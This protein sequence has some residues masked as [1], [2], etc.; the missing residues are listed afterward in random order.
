MGT[1]IAFIFKT[2]M[3][4]ALHA[5]SWLTGLA[6]AAAA[7]TGILGICWFCAV[8]IGEKSTEHMLTHRV[9]L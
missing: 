7:A 1:A 3:L 2:T 9:K 8:K 4:A 6:G 5:L